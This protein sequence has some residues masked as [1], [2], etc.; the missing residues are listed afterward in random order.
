MMIATFA[1]LLGA[2][3]CDTCPFR[4]LPVGVI[5]LQDSTFVVGC[6]A[7]RLLARGP[8]PGGYVYISYGPAETQRCKAND[9]SDA[10]ACQIVNGS[11][12]SSPV[13]APV[14]SGVRSGRIRSAWTERFDHDTDTREHE[15]YEAYLA[16]GGNGARV[17]YLAVVDVHGG[18]AV[19]RG[20]VEE[21]LQSRPID[22]RLDLQFL[23]RVIVGRSGPASV[24]RSR[25]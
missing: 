9:G 3:A 20:Y 1:V 25:P 13:N 10:L 16:N 18:Y 5:E 21:F 4:P 14:V 7:A 22:D 2:L 24:V 11:D 6:D 17:L 19:I 8:Q 23:Y 12:W 15:C